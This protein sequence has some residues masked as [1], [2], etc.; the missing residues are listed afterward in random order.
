VHT[1][2]IED[3]MQHHVVIVVVALPPLRFGGGKQRSSSYG[4][5][6]FTELLRD[7]PPAFGRSLSNH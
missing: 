2:N 3:L 1:K 4:F 6:D 7:K 5:T